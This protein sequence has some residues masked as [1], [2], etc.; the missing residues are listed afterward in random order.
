MFVFEGDRLTIRDWAEQSTLAGGIVLDA[1]ASARAFH[2]AKRHRYLTRRADALDDPS[3]WIESLLERD[4]F[5]GRS[6]LL[7][8]SAFSQ[9]EIEDAV[10]HLLASGVAVIAGHGL[11]LAATW[12]ILLRSAAEAIDADHRLHPDRHGVPL[13]ELRSRFGSIEASAFDALVAEICNGGFARDGSVVRRTTHRPALPPALEATGSVL[14]AR[15]ATRPFNPPSRGMLAPDTTSAR[16]LRF[17]LETGE[18]VEVSA[19][20]VMTS[21]HLK[22]ARDIVVAVIRERGA[23]TLGDIRA[24]LDCSRRVLVPLLVTSTA[25]A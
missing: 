8:R 21:E 12:A 11:C 9:A 17:L 10:S 23:A 25:R 1:D 20:L 3:A 7:V 5:V 24:R 15:L 6:G 18:A 22:R 4:T 13:T 14:R 19:D 16:A 2:S